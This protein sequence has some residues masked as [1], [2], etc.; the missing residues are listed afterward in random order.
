MENLTKFVEYLN[1]E[2]SS[3]EAQCISDGMKNMFVEMF[4]KEDGTLDEKDYSYL[5]LEDNKNQEDGHIKEPERILRP[6]KSSFISC[7]ST[8]FML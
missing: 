5:F 6:K 4:L 1:N 3:K 2:W 7:K 8:F